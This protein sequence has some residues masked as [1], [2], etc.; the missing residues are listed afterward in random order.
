MNSNSA[1]F[2]GG[3]AFAMDNASFGMT[4]CAVISNRADEVEIRHIPYDFVLPHSDI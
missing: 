1:S 4:S 3:A 2:D